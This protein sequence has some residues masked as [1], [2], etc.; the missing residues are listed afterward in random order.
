MLHSIADG[1]RWAL[2]CAFALSSLEKLGTLKSGAA[3]WQPVIL[4]S[5]RRRRHAR[6]LIAA[7]L[8][9]DLI[10]MLT[11][12][13]RASS[14]AAMSASLIV[15]YTWAYVGL[16]GRSGVQEDGCHCFWG[17]MNTRTLRGLI[18]RNS[19]LLGLALLVMAVTPS[20]SVRSPMWTLA[21]LGMVPSIAAIADSWG[22]DAEGAA[23]KASSRAQSSGE[24]T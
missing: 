4:G 5:D 24:T 22:R 7:S 18:C 17:V 16:R 12:L 6:S 15:L 10:T 20:I 19:A 2:T 3:A 1:S 14:G 11:L 9:A 21:L 13:L 23:P 8:V